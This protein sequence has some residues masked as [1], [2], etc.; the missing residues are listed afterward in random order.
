MPGLDAAS[1]VGCCLNRN[2]VDV[3]VSLADNIVRGTLGVLIGLLALDHIYHQRR[4]HRPL[5]D[6]RL[7]CGLTQKLDP[8]RRSYIRCCES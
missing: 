8:E 2:N 5:L 4:Q 7:T 3:F 1:R 6:H